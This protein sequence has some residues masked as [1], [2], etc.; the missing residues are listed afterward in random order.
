MSV[1]RRS[2]A[3]L[4][5]SFRPARMAVVQTPQLGF[6]SVSAHLGGVCVGNTLVSGA[7]VEPVSAE[8]GAARFLIRPPIVVFSPIRTFAPIDS[9]LSSP[10]TLSHLAVQ[11]RLDSATWWRIRPDLPR[12]PVSSG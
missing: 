10:L 6:V 3:S 8:D 9:C 5:P 12:H 1:L 4:D 11:S 2:A 7:T